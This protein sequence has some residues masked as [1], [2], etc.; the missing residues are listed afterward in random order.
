MSFL[1]VSQQS[2]GRMVGTLMQEAQAMLL[3]QALEAG[4]NA[5]LGVNYNI[6]NDSSGETGRKKMVIVSCYGR[7][8]CVGVYH[9]VPREEAVSFAHTSV[10]V[11]H[12][13]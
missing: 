13:Q 4:C 10:H 11:T 12:C 5:V 1:L 8:S 6:T 9:L 3:Q 2:M 7:W